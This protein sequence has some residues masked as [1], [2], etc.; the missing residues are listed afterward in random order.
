MPGPESTIDAIKAKRAA[1]QL[2]CETLNAQG[3]RSQ[4]F[5]NEIHDK[6][7]NARGRFAAYN[8]LITELEP[9]AADAP[10]KE[11]TDETPP[12]LT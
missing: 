9:L 2:E 5:L 7:V 3:V 10:P 1:A 12:H 8:E 11:P 4:N 6:L